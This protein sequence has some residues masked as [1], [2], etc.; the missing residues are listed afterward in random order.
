[1]S[2]GYVLSTKA[3]VRTIEDANNTFFRV[4]LLLARIKGV[5]QPRRSTRAGRTRATKAPQLISARIRWCVAALAV[6]G[7]GFYRDSLPALFSLPSTRPGFA[8]HRVDPIVGRRLVLRRGGEA[9]LA[10]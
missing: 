10:A 1:M 8:G 7:G 5:G 2:L 4:N 3:N 6:A 9:P